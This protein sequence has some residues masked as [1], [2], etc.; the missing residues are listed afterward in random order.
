[1]KLIEEIKKTLT[2]E[3]RS[4]SR[5]S[6]YLEAVIETK[7]LGLLNPILRKHLGPARKESGKEGDLPLE[8]Q[9]IVDSLG[10]L[11]KEQSF[12]CRRERDEVAFVALWPWQSDPGKV[13]L[14][15]GVNRLV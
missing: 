1:M 9:K 7:D 15:C 12:F 11:R 10:G 8:I 14:K 2:M 6:E 13:T 3:I 4:N 5:G